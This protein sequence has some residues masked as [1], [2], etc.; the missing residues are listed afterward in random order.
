MTVPSF[1]RFIFS[2]NMDAFTLSMLSLSSAHY[3]A[4][5]FSMTAV[6][7]DPSGPLSVVVYDTPFTFACIWYYTTMGGSRPYFTNSEYRFAVSGF[8]EPKKM[9]SGSITST[10]ELSSPKI[11]IHHHHHLENGSSISGTHIISGVAFA[12]I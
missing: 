12:S 9:G 10:I 8:A 6:T 3:T 1:F 5:P 11:I 7:E 4:T 2:I